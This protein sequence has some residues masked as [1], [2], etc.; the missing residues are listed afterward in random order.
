MAKYLK[1]TCEECGEKDWCRTVDG[2]P[3]C[4]ECLDAW[5]GDGGLTDADAIRDY[6]VQLSDDSPGGPSDAD[7]GL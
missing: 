5:G 1:G 6:F 4:I 2:G 3:V 7:P